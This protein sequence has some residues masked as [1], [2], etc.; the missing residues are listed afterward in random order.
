[1]GLI[2]ERFVARSR[3]YAKRM[4]LRYW[5]LNQADLQISLQEFNRRCVTIGD[6]STILFLRRTLD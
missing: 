1:M 3:A 5:A 4:A 2:Q 6:G